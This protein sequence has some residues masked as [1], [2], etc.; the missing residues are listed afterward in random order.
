MKRIIK[1]ADLEYYNANVRQKAVG[2]CVK[3][4][5]SL[6]YNKSYTEVSK[7]CREQEKATHFAFNSK[8]SIERL[9]KQY[10]ILSQGQYYRTDDKPTVNDFADSHSGTWLLLCG[11]TNNS[12]STHMVAVINGTIYDTW[13][14][15]T[16][17]VYNYYEVSKGAYETSDIKDHMDELIDYAYDLIDKTATKYQAK[18]K[19]DGHFERYAD[20]AVKGYAFEIPYMYTW[21]GKEDVHPDATHRML[22]NK[23]ENGF[24]AVFTF[25]PTTEF[26]EA[27][28]IV[29]KNAK[30]KTY[31]FFYYLYQDF[32]QAKEA[33]EL[34]DDMPR[35]Q[36][37]MYFRDGREKRFYNSLPLWIKHLT[38]NIDVQ[39]PGQYSDSYE[40]YID[41]L[42]NDPHQ[43]VVEFAAYDSKGILNEIEI[44]KKSY[45]RPYDDYNPIDEDVI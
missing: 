37:R 23:N 19:L 16:Y 25:T 34:V 6:A 9:L 2:D 41:P 26:D 1:A 3:R 12:G 21:N 8:Y 38:R 5:I 42:P 33:A 11:K 20:A 32:K 30:E 36:E 45:K 13:D 15:G 10:G 28:R 29:E 43:Q 22:N 35:S 27:K 4:A 18:Y 39:K 44:Y 40:L 14:S 31:N 24:V 17:L 7:D